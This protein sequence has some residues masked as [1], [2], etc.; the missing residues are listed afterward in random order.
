MPRNVSDFIKQILR[1]RPATGHHLIS[2]LMPKKRLSDNKESE[3]LQGLYLQSINALIDS[4]PCAGGAKREEAC[5]KIF[6]LLAF[7]D[8]EPYWNYLQIRQLFTRLVTLTRADGANFSV[9]RVMEAVTGRRRGYLM[10]ELA[11]LLQEVDV[12]GALEVPGDLSEE[13]QR[14]TLRLL[15]GKD[16]DA[17]WQRYFVSCLKW[18]KH[19]LGLIMV[20]GDFL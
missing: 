14:A 18:N 2:F 19:G 12:S 9:E 6:R 20:G 15:T 4:L 3:A 10:E 5:D 1:D 13:E 8:P 17:C 11:K 7:Y 16:R